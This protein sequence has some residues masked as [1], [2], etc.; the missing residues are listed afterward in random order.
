MLMWSVGNLEQP[1]PKSWVAKLLVAT[2][3]GELERLCGGYVVLVC[4]ALCGS[5]C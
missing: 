3:V 4:G 2:Q 5:F 1:P